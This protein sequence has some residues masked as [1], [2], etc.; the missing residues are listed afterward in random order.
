MKIKLLHEQ[1]N[2]NFLLKNSNF[3][4][5]QSYVISKWIRSA[6]IFNY[7]YNTS[8]YNIPF[9]IMIPL[10][11]FWFILI[12]AGSWYGVL[13]ILFLYLLFYFENILLIYSIFVINKLNINN[14]KN[15]CVKHPSSIKVSD[16]IFYDYN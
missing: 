6:A 13:I 14:K 4:N 5:N 10:F 2:K 11:I 7:F 1:Q 8:N 16:L 3:R 12:L 15:A 9:M